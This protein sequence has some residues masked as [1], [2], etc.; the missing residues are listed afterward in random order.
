[1]FAIAY[2][3][4][5]V[6]GSQSWRRGEIVLDFPVVQYSIGLLPWV[7]SIW[8]DTPWNLAL[9][10]L[11]VLID[12]TLILALSGHQVLERI[13]AH[14]TARA[15]D[16]RRPRSRRPGNRMS[17][18]IRGLSVD[19]AHLSE[20]LG[21]F[22]I[23]VL[24]ESVVQIV[25][26]AAT[27]HYDVGLLTTGIAS[28]ALL[29]GMFGLSVV[30]GY[31]GLPHL[32]AGRIPARA[33]LALHCLVTGVV[34]TVAVSLS[35]VMQDG[36]QPLPDQSRWLLC[37]AVAAYFALGVLTSVASHSSDRQRTLSRITTGIAVPLLLG[38][39][40]TDAGGRTIV[41]YLALIV[42]AHLYYERRLAP[43]RSAN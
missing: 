30:Y 42:L 34:A 15:A 12:L 26:A 13:Q 10:A 43:V 41:L 27:A 7:V 24:G 36:S 37:G 25:D 33:A 9:W 31:A 5:R 17:P 18:D 28:F 20:R 1:M 3:A 22:V 29:A 32:R 8:V 38:L 40:V 6:Y 39:L 23:I 35:H 21:L 4:T 11:G 14:F 19:P 2:I 16:R